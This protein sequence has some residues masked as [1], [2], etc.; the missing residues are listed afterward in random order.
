MA[1]AERIALGHMR[2]VQERAAATGDDLLLAVGA[3]VTLVV[4]QVA[5]EEHGDLTAEHALL[6]I[7]QGIVRVTGDVRIALGVDPLRARY[8]EDDV[9]V[10]AHLARHLA[11][12][13]L[14]R[15]VHLG[16]ELQVD[17]AEPP[18]AGQLHREV[19][20]RLPGG[21]TREAALGTTEEPR[22]RDQAVEPVV[23][24]GHGEYLGLAVGRGEGRGVRR[25]GALF[26][27]AARGIRV[28]LV[29]A[30]HE[31][32]AGARMHG[33]AVRALHIE[34]RCGD[35]ARHGVGRVEAVADIAHE[36]EPEI[37]L[38]RIGLE[39]EHALRL[40][41]ERLD[42]ARVGVAPEEVGDGHHPRRLREHAGVVPAD[43]LRL[44]GGNGWFAHRQPPRKVLAGGCFSTERV[45]SQPLTATNAPPPNRPTSHSVA[46]KLYCTS[47][48]SRAMK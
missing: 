14:L 28:D 38:G 24:A 36:V 46:S 45:A 21:A 42:E 44:G 31:H 3:L 37:A 27:G 11:E 6:E 16:A 26:V 5:G 25:L 8:A 10:L 34:L 30:E 22:E 17:G 4:V 7:A 15:L 23:V 39:T 1:G 9:R 20:A 2:R 35:A 12:V 43:H 48:N 33:L 13:G 29:A 19:A 18:V 40:V 32:A 41:R 47:R